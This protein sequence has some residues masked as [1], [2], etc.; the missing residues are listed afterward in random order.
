LQPNCPST[1]WYV[2]LLHSLHFLSE[3][4]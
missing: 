4:S 3:A 1:S 2:P